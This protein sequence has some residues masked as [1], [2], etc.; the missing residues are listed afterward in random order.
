MLQDNFSVLAVGADGFDEISFLALTSVMI[1]TCP[2][3]WE[4]NKNYDVLMNNNAWNPNF[5]F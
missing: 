5:S 3:I 2:E 4:E 1:P